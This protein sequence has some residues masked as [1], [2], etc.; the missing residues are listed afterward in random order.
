MSS[1]DP[2]HSVEFEAESRERLTRLETRQETVHDKVEQVRE[3][4]DEV[5]D[6]LEDIRE[7]AVTEEDIAEL[8]NASESNTISRERKDAA[9]QALVTFSGVLAGIAGYAQFIA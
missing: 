6:R 4:Q 5:L 7:T 8:E 9:L 2:T 3:G 1:E